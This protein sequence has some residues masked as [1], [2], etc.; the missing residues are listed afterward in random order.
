MT[1]SD[2]VV[3]DSL[4]NSLLKS[5]QMVLLRTVKRLM[6]LNAID[7]QKVL[8]DF[9]DRGG[10]TEG[11]VNVIYSV[12]YSSGTDGQTRVCLL[13][14]RE[15][16]SLKATLEASALEGLIANVYG[17][18][19]KPQ[20]EDN[21]TNALDALN[22]LELDSLPKINTP[23]FINRQITCS[24]KGENFS[25]QASPLQATTHSINAERVAASHSKKTAEVASKAKSDALPVKRK[26]AQAGGFFDNV[27]KKKTLVEEEP[28]CGKPEPQAP[29]ARPAPATKT[30]ALASKISKASEHKTPKKIVP[31][32]A[33][34][35]F[36]QKSD[37]D[38]KLVDDLLNFS[39]SDGHSAKDVSVSPPSKKR[40]EPD[41]ETDDSPR[42]AKSSEVNFSGIADDGTKEPVV[43]DAPAAASSTKKLRKRRKITRTEKCKDEHGYVIFRDV[44]EWESYSED[45]DTGNAPAKLTDGPALAPPSRPKLT[46]KAV[47]KGAKQATL[48][49]FFTKKS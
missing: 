35:D 36:K 40:R 5:N 18:C 3:E 2:H 7:A 1:K 30:D 39:A 8:V 20:K 10:A 13:D 31:S 44:T 43:A 33:A 46:D 45:E 4:L 28:V 22:K 47:P 19:S 41:T 32:L 21:F 24:A 27:A 23:S 11:D 29:V 26:A 49:S 6:Q 48:T 15:L 17:L 38:K 42:L 16:E 14:S 9:I 34:V 25:K 12:V 37:T